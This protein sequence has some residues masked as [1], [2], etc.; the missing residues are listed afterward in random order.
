VKEELGEVVVLDPVGGGEV[1]EAGG[2]LLEPPPLPAYGRQ[3]RWP[4]VRSLT[5]YFPESHFITAPSAGPHACPQHRQF[6]RPHEELTYTAAITTAVS[7]L[8]T[9]TATGTAESS[10]NV[11]TGGILAAEVVVRAAS[12]PT[13]DVHS[14]S[15][16]GL[17]AEEITWSETTH[18]SVALFAVDGGSDDILIINRDDPPITEL[19]THCTTDNVGKEKEY[20]DLTQV[21]VH[22]VFFP[23][24]KNDLRIIP[25][26]NIKTN[27]Y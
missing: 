14:R 6:G 9:L 23:M 5:Q 16:A 10:S 21:L 3:P 22:V 4:V 24:N 2:G 11:D 7:T 27:G 26:S 20:P 1:V 15:G 13:D 25:S 8:A 17:T 12:S 18:D 19:H